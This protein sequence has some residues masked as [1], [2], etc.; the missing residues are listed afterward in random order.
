MSDGTHPDMPRT[1]AEVR[2]SSW[3]GWIWTIPIA[4]LLLLGW[5]AA[6]SLLRGGENITIS[7]D[8]VHELKQSG[9]DVLYR[10]MKVGKVTGMALAK[11]GKSIDVSA[12]IDA[13]AATFLDTGT[14]FWL[15]GAEPSLADPSSLGA[16]LSGPTIVME[17]GPGEKAT[18]FVG[19]A[20]KPVVAD[21]AAQPQIYG[22]SLSGAVGS[23]KGGQP[24]KLRGFTV[25]E[26][27]DVG[28]RY[29]ARSGALA[30]PVT[31]ALYPSLFHIEGAAT[32]DAKA[33]LAAAIDRLIK[34]GLHARLERDPPLI[35]SAEVALEM[36]PD[37]KGGGTAV[38]DGVPQIPAAPGAGLDSIVDRVN[39]V[40]VDQIAQNVLAITQHLGTL[41]SSPQLDDTIAQLDATMQQIHRTTAA[42][43]P[44]IADLVDRLRKTSVQ[45]DGAVKDVASTAKTAQQTAKSADKVLGSAP[46]SQN[47]MQTA[48]R[49]ITEAARSVRELANYL[50]RHPEALIQ[51][52]SGE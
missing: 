9:A 26:V 52:R 21:P 46:T 25:G 2:R 5:W 41:V 20:H 35:G 17:P 24:V 6:R 11:D 51:G 28:F 43:G 13:G 8:D 48:M 19:L 1:Q 3:P 39:K 36:A 4:A 23:L 16:V 38:V 40:P 47:G 50:E 29:D 34:E 45:L 32:P 37:A 31:L 10:G 33:A 27:R 15:R 14:R 44:K 18:H 12:N 49:E 7:F 22:V 30:A 42:A